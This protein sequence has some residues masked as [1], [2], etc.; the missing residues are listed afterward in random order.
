[1][2]DQ[3]ALMIWNEIWI[4]GEGWKTVDV[5]HKRMG[6]DNRYIRFFCAPDYT[7]YID[8]LTSLK[9]GVERTNW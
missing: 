3:Y 2:D 5:R 4:D 9:F 7:S 1:M 6:S 8:Q